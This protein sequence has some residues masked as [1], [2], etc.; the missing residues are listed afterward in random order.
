MSSKYAVSIYFAS[1][2]AFCYTIGEID[3]IVLMYKTGISGENL[4]TG[5]TVKTWDDYY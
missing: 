2:W 4:V 1:S 3:R 5:V